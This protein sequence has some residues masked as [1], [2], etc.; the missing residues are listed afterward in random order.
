[1][2]DIGAGSGVLTTALLGSGA[3]VLALE[4]DPSLVDGLRRRF[5][6]REVTVV[7]AD[8]RGFS[9]P[10]KPFR[11]VSNLPFAGSGEILTS[12]LGDPRSGLLQADVI[13]QWELAQK[14]AAVWPA[15]MRAT[16]WRAWFELGIVGRLS[17]RAFAPPPHVDAA[18]LRLSRRARPLLPLEEHVRYRRFLAEAFGARVP[19]GRALRRHLSPRELRRLAAV[20]GFDAASHPRDL[21]ARQWA[22]LFVATRAR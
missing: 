17:R 2:V 7:A 13:V 10:R 6:G 9:W 15:T 22:G 16:Y 19:L 5:D 8:A 3:R 12:L 18:I 20:L 4:A 1:V 11:V 14:Q 21:D